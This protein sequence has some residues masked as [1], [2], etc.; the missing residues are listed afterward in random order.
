MDYDKITYL[1]WSIIVLIIIIAVSFLSNYGTN[2][3]QGSNFM[4]F[5]SWYIALIIINLFN[6]LANLLYHFFM[7]DLIGPRGLKGDTGE[8]GLP[9]K[10]SKCK[11]D[12]GNVAIKDTSISAT[13]NID[14][15]PL[16]G[17]D[18]I[19]FTDEKLNSLTSGSAITMTP[20]DQ[21]E[22]QDRIVDLESQLLSISS[23][24]ILTRIQAQKEDITFDLLS[25]L[26]PAQIGKLSLR[27]IEHLADMDR[28]KPSRSHTTQRLAPVFIKQLTMEQ[29]GLIPGDVFKYFTKADL[30][31]ASEV[32]AE[33]VTAEAGTAATAGNDAATALPEKT[34]PEKVEE[35]RALAGTQAAGFGKI[36]V[37][38]L[39]Q[40]QIGKIKDPSGLTVDELTSESQTTNEN[41]DP[42]LGTGNKARIIQLLKQVDIEQIKTTEDT[43]ATDAATA[44]TD[45]AA[46]TP[47]KN[48]ICPTLEDLQVLNPKTEGTSPTLKSIFCPDAA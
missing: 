37:Q 47:I 21:Q 32:K 22:K 46:A 38:L 27:D 23:P 8:R 17:G 40:E 15:Y 1:T 12:L 44:G 18:G 13:S 26:G 2:L 11:C 19:T 29:I 36:I 14:S 39:T 45:V 4:T 41:G 3:F 48:A 20:P 28:K 42:Y 6:I 33:T 24:E 35:A 30:N 34:P 10:D 31:T 9:G 43:A 7:K 25:K 5:Y 16:K